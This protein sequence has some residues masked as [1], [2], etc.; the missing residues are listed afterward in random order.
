MNFV[1]DYVC[2][3]VLTGNVQTKQTSRIKKTA[4]QQLFE[5]LLVVSGLLEMVKSVF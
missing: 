5:L 3:Y 4:V 1:A 2:L